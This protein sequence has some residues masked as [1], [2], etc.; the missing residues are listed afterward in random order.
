MPLLKLWNSL[1]GRSAEPAQPAKLDVVEAV[2]GVEPQ[3]IQPSATAP[4]KMANTLKP[5]KTQPTPKKR[6]KL[7][8]FAGPS[9][10][11][12]LIKNLRGVSA[13]T[14]LEISVG[15]GSRAI[16]VVQT[17][18]GDRATPVRYI[19]LDQFEMAGGETTLMQ[20]H[21]AMRSAGVRV[22]VY[23]ETL[24][25]GLARVA[26]TVGPVDLVLFSKPQSEWDSPEVR[27]LLTKV[28]KPSTVVLVCEGD[29]W[30]VLGQASEA[31]GVGSTRKAA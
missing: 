20:F 29:V 14:V 30:Q 31:K 15:D 21:Q 23:P 12:S 16:E 3:A 5:A 26:H 22:Q 28:C 8:L 13:E 1:R 11:A 10:H 19:A 25:R 27:G 9:P 6:S 7:S 4:E 18:A 2:G 24:D 17:L